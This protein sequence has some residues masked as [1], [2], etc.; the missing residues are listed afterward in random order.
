MVMLPVVSAVVPL[1]RAMSMGKDFTKSHSSPPNSTT[2]TRSSVAL[3][4]TLPP[5]MRGSTNVP[6]PTLEKTPWAFFRPRRGIDSVSPLGEN[7]TL[8]IHCPTPSGR[9]SALDHSGRR[10]LAEQTFMGQP[11]SPLSFASPSPEENSS[12][13][14]IGS[15]FSRNRFS[16][17]MISSSEIIFVP[18]EPA[19]AITSP[20]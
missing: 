12:V 4:L 3:A 8:R 5:S 9:S 14:S 1:I 6:R 17:A 16:R 10:S 18:T 15:L 19:A 20:S 2:S 7:Y 11:V 13:I